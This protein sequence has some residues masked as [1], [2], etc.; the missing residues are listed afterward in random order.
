MKKLLFILLLV[1]FVIFVKTIFDP[2]VYEP[3]RLEADN[4]V[5]RQEYFGNG[6][7]K[8]YKNR[9]GIMYFN[10]IYP[11]IIKFETEFFADLDNMFL[12]IPLYSVL[13]ILGLRKFNEK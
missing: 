4:L 10:K 12:F 5:T 13:I 1:L 8:I 2:V 9:F 7:G 6:L 11:T 3:S